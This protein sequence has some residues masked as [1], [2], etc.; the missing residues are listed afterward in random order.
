MTPAPAVSYP[1]DLSDHECVILEPL[2]P[3]PKPGGRPRSVNLRMILNGIL[4]VLRSGCQ[5]RLLPRAYG[6]WSTVYAYS[7]AWRIAGV[8]VHLYTLLRERV[9]SQAGR[10]PSPSAAILDSQSV[11]RPNVATRMATMARRSSQDASAISRW[12]RWAWLSGRWCIRPTSR[13]VRLL[14]HMNVQITEVYLRDF[15]SRQA[16]QH[17]S[18]YSP[19]ATFRPPKGKPSTRFHSF[20]PPASDDETGAANEESNGTTD[21]H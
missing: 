14:G 7:R 8:W 4:Y 3:P 15:Q 20:L 9:R 5:W 21:A 11:R 12:T 6:P 13:T 17:H 18:A 10:A 1:T 2:L 16:R 19:L